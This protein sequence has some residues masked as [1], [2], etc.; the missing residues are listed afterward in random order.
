[1]RI[2]DLSGSVRIEVTD[3]GP[4]IP[5]DFRPR[6]F[7]KFSQADGN[8]KKGGTGLG[9]EICKRIMEQLNGSIGFES[10]PDER[11]TFFVELPERQ[12]VY[13]EEQEHA[14]EQPQ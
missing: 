3:H 14:N 9:L 5:E 4:G 12:D 8:T 2:I 10:L 7:D 6:V 1:V 11:T 13:A